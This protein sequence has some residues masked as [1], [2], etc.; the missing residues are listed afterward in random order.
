M[1]KQRPRVETAASAAAPSPVAGAWVRT[2]GSV[3]RAG[4][5]ATSVLLA[6]SASPEASEESLST[7]KFG[8]ACKAI[9]SR[10]VVNALV[11]D[12]T[13]LRQYKEKVRAGGGACVGSGR[14]ARTRCAPH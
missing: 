12:K 8:V 10:A 11:D 14:L 7:L 3:L 9:R 1:L 13:L 2:P 6:V 4:A 5:A